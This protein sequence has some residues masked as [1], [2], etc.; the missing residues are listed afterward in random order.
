[1]SN[2]NEQIESAA[3]TLLT[4]N[5]SRDD[6][7]DA[8]AEKSRQCLLRHPDVMPEDI[9]ESLCLL[10]DPDDKALLARFEK[11][12]AAAA[13][14]FLT[15]FPAAG[16]V[17]VMSTQTPP[18]IDLSPTAIA[19]G[20]VMLLTLVVAMASLFTGE[21]TLKRKLLAAL[22]SRSYA[23]RGADTFLPHQA[24]R[25]ENA[26]T[27]SKLKMYADDVA[28]IVFDAELKRLVIE[29][30][31]YRYIIHPADVELITP[32]QCPGQ[33]GPAAVQLDYRVGGMELSLA[34]MLPNIA[35][36]FFPFWSNNVASKLC[37]RIRE[38]LG[39]TA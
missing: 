28:M 35:P 24:V 5:R 4:D 11:G 26:R 34:L 32:F 20:S 18:G 25:M 16:V 8:V 12:G 22:K 3:M 7:R 37:N 14:A 13:I 38:T 21:A 6:F 1:M 31:R 9:G 29:G 36:R 33:H 19:A 15:I 39:L 17:F 30:L 2:A 23:L 10:T 27:A